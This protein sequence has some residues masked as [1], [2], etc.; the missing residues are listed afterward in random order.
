[1]SIIRTGS[2]ILV[3]L[4]ELMNSVIIL[5]INKYHVTVSVPKDFYVHAVT[6]VTSGKVVNVLFL[7]EAY[8]IKN[9]SPRGY[10]VVKNLG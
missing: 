8:G 2:P 6:M 9:N 4:I 3:E 5:S 10:Y 7:I 1:M